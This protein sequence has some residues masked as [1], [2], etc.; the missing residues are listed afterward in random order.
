VYV[1]DIAA[2]AA[3]VLANR[4]RPQRNLWFSAPRFRGAFEPES[5]GKVSLNQTVAGMAIQL[6][7]NC[8]PKAANSES[9][10][11]SPAMRQRTICFGIRCRQHDV[12]IRVIGTVGTEDKRNSGI[13]QGLQWVHVVCLVKDAVL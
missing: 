12:D 3:R 5:H 2:V 8:T 6:Y 11:I 9:L 7:R 1:G 4:W 10:F 13:H